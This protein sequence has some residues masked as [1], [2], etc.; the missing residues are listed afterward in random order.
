MRSPSTRL[1]TG[2][3]G[4][5]LIAGCGSDVAAG[6]APVISSLTLDPSSVAHGTVMISARFTV[7]D[8]DLDANAFQ[9]RL[10][11]PGGASSSL[12][13]AMITGLAG[14]SGVPVTVGL[15]LALNVAGQFTL[16]FQVNDAA[17]HAS[18]R[19]SGVVTVT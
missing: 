17:G 5:A 1:V 15:T 9:V 4:L 10:I 13:P 11:S 12:G 19:L 3:L 7:T 2:L 6:S 8:A 18:N 16:E 14:H